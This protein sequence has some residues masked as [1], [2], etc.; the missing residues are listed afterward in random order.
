MFTLP[1][2]DRFSSSPVGDKDKPQRL[3][4]LVTPVYGV[5]S[6]AAIE[7]AGKINGCGTQM[8]TFPAPEAWPVGQETDTQWTI[9]VIILLGGCHDGDILLIWEPCDVSAKTDHRKWC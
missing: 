8:S 6:N 1:T 2:L 7:E 9:S 4:Q 3:V 5:C